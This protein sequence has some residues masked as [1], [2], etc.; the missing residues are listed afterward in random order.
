MKTTPKKSFESLRLFQ[1]RL[2]HYSYPASDSNSFKKSFESFQNQ[3]LK[4]F[5]FD[6]V[7]YVVSDKSNKYF[8]QQNLDRLLSIVNEYAFTIIYK[9]TIV[10]LQGLTPP[11]NFHAW[12]FLTQIFVDISKAKIVDI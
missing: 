3:S 10:C 8:Y 2:F 1:V 9:L 11:S 5:V 12:D 6:C 4:E 7:K